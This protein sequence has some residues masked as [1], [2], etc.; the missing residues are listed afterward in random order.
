MK[1]KII[2]VIVIFIMIILIFS[3]KKTKV[4]NGVNFNN[5]EYSNEVYELMLN[6]LS[7]DITNVDEAEMTREEQEFYNKHLIDDENEYNNEIY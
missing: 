3:L 5:T 2:L 6:T 4:Q 1:N 7:R